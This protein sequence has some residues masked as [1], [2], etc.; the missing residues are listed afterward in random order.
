MHD[1]SAYDCCPG[2]PH[3]PTVPAALDAHPLVLEQYVPGAVEL[4]RDDYVKDGN[5]TF[6]SKAERGRR[7]G[8][9]TSALACAEAARGRAYALAWRA[10]MKPYFDA[11]YGPEPT[12]GLRGDVRQQGLSFARRWRERPRAAIGHIPF[13]RER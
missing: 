7:G 13:G 2:V 11:L 3:E 6:L 1:A 4:R 8:L 12:S 10:R 9:R 5:G